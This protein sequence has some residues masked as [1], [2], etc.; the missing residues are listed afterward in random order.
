[1][2][3]TEKILQGQDVS[4]MSSVSDL[5]LSDHH[6]SLDDTIHILYIDD[7][8][9]MVLFFQTYIK[10]IGSFQVFPVRN[11]EEAIKLLSQEHQYDVIVSDYHMPGMDGIEVLKQSRTI[12]GVPPFILFTGKGREEVVMEAINNGA[13]FLPPERW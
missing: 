12:P 2:S 5:S 11:G 4:G 1:M 6:L 3:Q 9:D 7:D 8:P 10:R 13:A